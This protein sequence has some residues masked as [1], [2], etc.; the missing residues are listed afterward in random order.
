MNANEAEII[1]AVAALRSMTDPRGWDLLHALR[2]VALAQAKVEEQA[3]ELVA[4]LPRAFRCDPDESAVLADPYPISDPKHNGFHS[5]HV[6]LYDL[7]R[8]GK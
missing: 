2:D 3:D 8:E 5:L 6:D 4:A 1:T 7:Y